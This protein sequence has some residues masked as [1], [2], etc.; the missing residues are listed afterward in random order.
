M[1]RSRG[2][3]L[4]KR[5]SLGSD[6]DPVAQSYDKAKTFASEEVPV[7][8]I[9]GLARLLREIEDDQYACIIRGCRLPHVAD[10]KIIRRV[11]RDHADTKAMI[12]DCPRRWVM[13]DIDGYPCPDGLDPTD[14]PLA[15]G[16]YLRDVLADRA[17]ELRDVA[18]W[19]QWSASHL[20]R[21][22]SELRAHFWV[23]LPEPVGRWELEAWFAVTGLDKVIDVSL[24]REVHP[25]Y[26]ARPIFD[27]VDDP[28][29][30]RKRSGLLPGRYDEARLRIPADTATRTRRRSSTRDVP[31]GY[32]PPSSLDELRTRS[33]QTSTP[34]AAA[35][36]RSECERLAATVPGGRHNAAYRAAAV[37]GAF[38]AGGALVFDDASDSLTSACA[39]CG[40]V[41]DPD[42]DIVTTL[43][44]GLLAGALEPRK[45]PPPTN[46]NRSR[47][48][49]DGQ[50]GK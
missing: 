7:D 20:L 30:G 10:A 31:D 40:L 39:A 1:L 2:P 25:H 21:D 46:E 18:G 3:I 26:T 9:R 38:V 49:S 48:T 27:G 35:A 15:V 23:W 11:S 50:K 28:L 24:A 41:D 43:T 8:G 16:R 19:L 6:G 45:S 37:A 44:D 22:L 29:P 34:Y 36:L 17:P 47:S 14:D 4:A 32:V 12:V 42:E 33:P 13:F 5:W